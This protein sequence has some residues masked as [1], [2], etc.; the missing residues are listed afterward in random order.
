MKSFSFEMWCEIKRDVCCIVI[1]LCIKCALTDSTESG[2]LSGKERFSPQGSIKSV[3]TDELISILEISTPEFLLENNNT[4]LTTVQLIT[5]RLTSRCVARCRATAS[6]VRL[7]RICANRVPFHSF[8]K[9]SGVAYEQK[10]KGYIEAFEVLRLLGSNPLV[11]SR[12]LQA[13]IV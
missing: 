8:V 5:R 13:V 12:A 2:M 11:R 3:L 4:V 9:S 1:C 6:F 10:R 7:K